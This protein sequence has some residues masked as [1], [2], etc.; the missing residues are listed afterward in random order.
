MF[1]RKKKKSP[2]IEKLVPV[3]GFQVEVVLSE[4][5]EKLIIDNKESIVVRTLFSGLPLDDNIDD[6]SWEKY[7]ELHLGWAHVELFD[8]RIAKFV[9][10]TIPEKK[11]N[12]LKDKDYDLQINVFTG[13]KSSKNN[14]IS[15]D[16]YGG[17][18]SQVAG[19]KIVLKGKLIRE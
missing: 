14:L 7:G 19:K 11:Y 6:F 12:Q 16:Y 3:P 13:R 18:I 10:V 1:K 5:A 9:D 17:K 15:V 4:K 2:H 8:S